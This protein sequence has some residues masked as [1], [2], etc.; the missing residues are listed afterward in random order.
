MHAE[1]PTE[2]FVNRCITREHVNG[3]QILPW[4]CFVWKERSYI[5]LQSLESMQLV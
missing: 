5:Q 2:S 3:V 1:V 4:R